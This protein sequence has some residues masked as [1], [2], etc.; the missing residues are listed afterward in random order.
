MVVKHVK[1]RLEKEKVSDP[2][3]FT[4]VCVC[5]V[6]VHDHMQKLQVF[7]TERDKK[8]NYQ[9]ELWEIPADF[10]ERRTGVFPHVLYT[11]GPRH[12]ES[13]IIAQ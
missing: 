2:C 12:L 5:V 10:D 3:L 11:P 6:H 9:D 7:N 8:G 4:S 13:E 1:I